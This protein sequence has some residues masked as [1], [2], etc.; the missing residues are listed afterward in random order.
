[1]L[2]LNAPEK[3]ESHSKNVK[4]LHFG[5]VKRPE[6][7]KKGKSSKDQGSNFVHSVAKSILASPSPTF[8]VTTILNCPVKLNCQSLRK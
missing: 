4:Y 1:M 6:H 5:L 8:S 3:V 7:R 2:F